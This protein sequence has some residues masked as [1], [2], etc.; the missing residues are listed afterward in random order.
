VSKGPDF[1]GG[2]CRL[3][4]AFRLGS[5]I[6]PDPALD[7]SGERTVSSEKCNDFYISDSTESL[8]LPRV[9][10]S[11]RR[12]LVRGRTFSWV[13]FLGLRSVSRSLW[14]WLTHPPTVRLSNVG[15]R[16]A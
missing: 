3:P 12:D 10:V 11:S 16:E 13:C 15:E 2:L 9:T 5:D 1:W 7:L 8:A 4:L 6:T 14:T